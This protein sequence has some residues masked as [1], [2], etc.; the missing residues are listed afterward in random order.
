MT[1]V[2]VFTY[3]IEEFHIGN[4]DNS[5]RKGLRRARESKIKSRKINAILND[6]NVSE[7]QCSNIDMSLR[8]DWRT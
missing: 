2:F 5:S 6:Y 3:L 7:I 1:T 4:E 8:R